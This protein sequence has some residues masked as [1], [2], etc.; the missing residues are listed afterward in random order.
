MADCDPYWEECEDTYGAEEEYY[1]EETGDNEMEEEEAAALSPFSYVWGL[2]PIAQVAIGY[3]VKDKY[4]DGNF[5]A[6]AAVVADVANNDYADAAAATK[7]WDDGDQVSGWSMLANLTLFP[8][9]LGLLLWIAN[10]AAG[11]NGGPI[12]M[13]FVRWSEVNTLLTIAMPIL[14]NSAKGNYK[15]C[16]ADF[17]PT[18][19]ANEK[20]EYCYDGTVPTDAA[21]AKF[22]DKEAAG[23]ATNAMIAGIVAFLVSAVSFMPLMNDLSLY[24]EELCEDEDGNEIEC[25]EDEEAQAEDDSAECYEDYYGEL[26]CPEE[27]AAEED[28]G[29]EDQWWM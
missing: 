20:K 11:N 15:E 25:P 18:A 24:G 8:G 27:D 9:A 7:A 19:A 17:D 3:M 29:A 5:D 23:L 26:V 4:V 1:A 28:Y 12:H 21:D 2:V 22:Q 10:A 16:T 13:I 6:L 14:A